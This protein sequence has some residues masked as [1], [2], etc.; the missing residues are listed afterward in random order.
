MLC[1]IAHE[2]GQFRFIGLPD[3]AA[4]AEPPIYQSDGTRWSSIWRQNSGFYHI[5]K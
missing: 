3:S 2:V 1:F 5:F 4:Q